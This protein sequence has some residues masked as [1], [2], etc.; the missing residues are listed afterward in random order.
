MNTD[1]KEVRHDMN[2][3]IEEELIA[4]CVE[5]GYVQVVRA[6]ERVKRDVVGRS[7][8]RHH[9]FQATVGA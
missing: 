9:A 3:A 2:H 4:L 8:D 6:M 5:Y 7:P 1:T